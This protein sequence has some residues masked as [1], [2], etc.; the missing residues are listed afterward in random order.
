M[1]ALDRAVRRAFREAMLSAI[2]TPEFRACL[3]AEL[4]REAETPPAPAPD[5]RL[6]RAMLRD[7]ATLDARKAE[8]NRKRSET[9]KANAELRRLQQRQDRP[10]TPPTSPGGFQPVS[11]DVAEAKQ[12]ILAG[13]RAR[14]VAEEYGWP[15]PYA[16]WLC[17]S[18]DAD[19]AA[20]GATS[21]RDA[22]P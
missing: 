9:Q 16:Q 15:L 5:P 18:I 6:V 13:R 22:R 21:S 4:A 8:A 2:K 14:W 12:Q 11:E 17:A 1:T 10:A 19:R 20:A 3:A 7:A